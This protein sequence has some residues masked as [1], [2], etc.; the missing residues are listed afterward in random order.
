MTKNPYKSKWKYEGR[1]FAPFDL[2]G[3]G[4]PT[5]SYES[6][7]KIYSDRQPR[8][9]IYEVSVKGKDGNYKKGYQVWETQNIY[10]KGKKPSMWSFEG[11]KTKKSKVFTNLKD[12]QE[13]AKTK[14]PY[15]ER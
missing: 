5:Y 11:M 1:E 9:H 2:S 10:T 6:N 15:R 13:Y 7:T 14:E 3:K 12:A 4:I 8:R